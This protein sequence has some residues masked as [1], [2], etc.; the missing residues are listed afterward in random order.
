VGIIRILEEHVANLI[1]AGEVVERPASVVKEL[2]ENAIDAGADIVRVYIEEGGLKLIRV[3]DNGKGMAAE[4]VP[5][6]FQRH[7]T[8]KVSDSRDLFHIRTLGFRGEALPSIASVARVECVTSPDR[9]GLGTLIAIE[10]G[11]VKRIEDART[12]QGTDISV[13]DLF[14]HTPARLKYMKTV[15]TEFGHISD[16]MYRLALAHPRIAFSLYHQDKQVFST[17]GGGDLQQTIAAIYGTATARAM[18]PV[19]A[20]NADF[21][22]S[23]WIGK[24]ELTR[25]NRYGMTTIVNGRYVRS[26]PLQT[27]IMQA[28][29]TLLPI[30]RYPLV[31][32]QLTMDPSLVD[33]NVHPAKLEVRFSKERELT[34][35]VEE[36]LRK[37]L[38][39]T[40]LI[41]RMQAPQAKKNVIQEQLAF[42][43]AGKLRAPLSDASLTNESRDTGKGW[44]ESATAP[45]AP[46]RGDIDEQSR[47]WA[48]PAAAGAAEAQARVQPGLGN[49]K[50]NLGANASSPAAP[51][52]GAGAAAYR[53]AFPTPTAQDRA[54][55]SQAARASSASKA[56]SQPQAA[57]SDAAELP[58]S[59]WQPYVEVAETEEPADSRRLPELRVIGQLH[60]TYIVAEDNS[61]LYLIDQHAAHERIN[62]ERFYRKFGQPVQA[63]QELLVPI[64]LEFTAAEAERLRDK[65]A[66][67]SQIGVYLEP[68]GGNTFIIRSVPEWMPKG[69]E[70]ELVL[71]MVDLVLQDKSLDIARLREKSAIL[72]ACKAS[73]KANDYLSR[74]E[75]ESLLRQLGECASPFTCP[76][77]R[78]IIVSFSSYELEKMFKRVM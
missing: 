23:G 29:H 8:S 53:S 19:Q 35:F 57:R 1:A 44:G 5:L 28:Y 42:Y 63:S 58:P 48:A 22:L 50:I 31:V 65:S 51:L 70:R 38:H 10:G 52:R 43:D 74:E 7:A 11:A 66:L 36:E 17:P 14:Y 16:Y 75:I 61:G 34:A 30:N 69:E 39:R 25:A 4:D 64:T 62:Y 15:Q 21:A 56:S 72:A 6:A 68:F 2:V 45:V 55:Q 27:A 33:V 67:F 18:L 60:G 77:G 40:N 41:P 71:E 13:R 47:G 49:G 37:Q 3:I 76:H 20:E 78:P 24:P 12:S 59:V 73:L 9:S 32:L 26:Y 46:N 54:G